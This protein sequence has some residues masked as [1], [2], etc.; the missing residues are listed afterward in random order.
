MSALTRVSYLKNSRYFMS[1]AMQKKIENFRRSFSTTDP[2]QFHD[3]L[4]Y[5]L[6]YIDNDKAIANL[7]KNFDAK[8][9]YIERPTKRRPDINTDLPE[10]KTEIENIAMCYLVLKDCANYSDRGIELKL[11][12]IIFQDGRNGLFRFKT[13]F[14]DPVINY[15]EENMS[16]ETH[17]Q[18][19]WANRIFVIALAFTIIGLV[20]VIRI[21]TDNLTILIIAFVSLPIF[22]AIMAFI[23]FQEKDLS[24][25][26]LLGIL[27]R[28][29][30]RT[31]Y[32]MKAILSSIK[33]Q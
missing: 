14:I 23:S 24:E 13:R 20:Y 6:N 22:V 9:Q 7:F 30:N 4:I 3:T 26:G 15:I 19:K 28:I 10:L 8:Y 29:I 21:G 17:S 2:E 33:K 18:I 32:L 12:G 5:F 1:I 31:G 11:G 16:K 27:Y 25:K